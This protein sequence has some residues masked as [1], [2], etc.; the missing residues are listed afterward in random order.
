MLQSKGIFPIKYQLVAD[1]HLHRRRSRA[2][3]IRKS[4]MEKKLQKNLKK[5]IST[6]KNISE[7]PTNLD[8][9]IKT[10]CVTSTEYFTYLGEVDAYN[11][12]LPKTQNVEDTGIPA[13]GQHCLDLVQSRLIRKLKNFLFGDFSSFLEVVTNWLKDDEEHISRNVTTAQLDEGISKL[14]N[15]SLLVPCSRRKDAI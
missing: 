15:V 9:S 3:A 7:K 1:G 13:L 2:Y 14:K 10:F 12:N 6:F 5:N 8:I 11:R 4:K